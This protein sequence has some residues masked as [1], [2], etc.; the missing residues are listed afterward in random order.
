MPSDQIAKVTH[1]SHEAWTREGLA[2][3]VVGASGDLAKKKTYPSLLSLYIDALLPPDVVI[4]G[5]ARS[6]MTDEQLRD[7]LRPYLSAKVKDDK[8]LND[9]LGRCFYQSGSGYGDVDGWERLNSKLTKIEEEDKV[10]DGIEKAN[11]LF[12]FAM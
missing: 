5:Y 12:Y 8:V 10:N 9:F 6:N 2:I 1:V 11:R 7:K 4:Y 3:I